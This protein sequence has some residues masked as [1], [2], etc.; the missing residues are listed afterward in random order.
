YR[1]RF[2]LP[3]RL[4]GIRTRFESHRAGNRSRYLHPPAYPVTGPGA[5]PRSRLEHFHIRASLASPLAVIAEGWTL[6]LVAALSAVACFADMP[7]PRL[8]I[9]APTSDVVI[10]WLVLGALVLAYIAI[11]SEAYGRQRTAA[12]GIEPGDVPAH[13][14]TRVRE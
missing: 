3:R 6:R 11:R 4:R 8:L 5:H 12:V 13:V 1:S 7:S 9:S 2:G 10:G 14:Q